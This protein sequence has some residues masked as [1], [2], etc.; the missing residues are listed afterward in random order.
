VTTL[1]WM[2]DSVCLKIVLILTKD[3]CTVCVECTIHSEII[4]DSLTVLLGDV[5]M[6]NLIFIHLEIVLVLVEDRCTICAK[7]IIGSENCFGR[8]R[9]YS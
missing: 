9:Q 2:L 8:T 6:R 4:L 1:K 5:G 7:C 3:S